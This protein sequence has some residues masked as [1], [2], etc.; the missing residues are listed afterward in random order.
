[1]SAS[2]STVVST[3]SGDHATDVWAWMAL[4]L[5]LLLILATTLFPFDFFFK[6]TPD[7]WEYHSLLLGWGKSDSL[8]I[9]KNVLLFFPLGFSLTWLVEKRKSGRVALAVTLS[10]SFGLSYVLEVL[11]IF[12]QAR[13]PSLIDVL[14][15]SLGGLLGFL[16]FRV[17]RA[18][19]RDCY[20]STVVKKSNK[21]LLMALMLYATSA[22]AIL[23]FLQLATSLSNWNKTFPL[24]LGNERTGDRPW[25]GYISGVYIADRGMSEIEV[26]H[27]FSKK[28]QSAAI[29]ESLVA[30]YPLA[31]L[32]GSYYDKIGHLPDLVWRGQPQDMQ[33]GQG[34]FL[35]SKYWLETATSAAYLTQRLAETSQFTLIAKVATSDTSQTGPA[36]IIS[37]SANPD[38]RNF[39]LGQ[40]G[41]NLIFRLRTPLTGENG[42]NPELIV[43]HVFSTK[44]AHHLIITYAKSVLRV[45]VDG[46]YN[47]QT[48]RL[49]PWAP[50]P[51]RN[52]FSFRAVDWVIF[53]SLY[54]ALIFVPIGVMLIAMLRIR[55]TGLEVQRL[56]I[57]FGIFLPSLLLE[58]ILIAISW[59]GM[60]LENLLL[61]MIF[62]ACPVVVLKFLKCYSA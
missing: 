9:L 27:A 42:V 10:V 49:T 34:I 37:L 5:S 2:E 20:T 44:N 55:R 26:A 61:G 16:Y 33:Q 35:G 19:A 23:I 38:Q 57:C 4:S 50:I 36:R 53:K 3:V 59:R 47:S 21:N 11:Q 14:S 17:G 41:S 31:G 24:L 12:L 52:L 6:E 28:D 45:Y 30:S 56:I 43:P 46:V 8:D 58:T 40:Q 7:K 25:H 62:T 29:G 22:F 15:N 54:Y 48:L 1:M 18:I 51:F 39:T 13:F 60:R 32:R